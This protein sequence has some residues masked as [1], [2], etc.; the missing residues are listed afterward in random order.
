MVVLA[1]RAQVV[2]STTGTGTVSLGTAVAGYQTLSEAGVSDGDTVRYVIEDGFDWEIGS[3]VY[4]ASGTTLSRSV[5]ESS[6]AGAAISLSGAAVVFVSATS[7][8]IQQPPSEGPFV[9]GDKTKLDGIATGAEVNTVDSV[10]TQ[11]GAVVL[12]ADDISD[13]TTTNKFT[14]AG[15]ISKLAGIETSADVTDTAN[16][17][18]AG[19]LMDSEVTNLAQVK[20]FD[21]ADYAT[22]AQGTLADSAVQ[23]NDTVTLG[24]VTA[25]LVAI[26]TSP[27]TWD[28]STDAVQLQS[29]SLWN[30]STSQI[31]LSQNEYYNG[32]YKYLNS[33]AATA[34]SQAGGDH[35]FKAAS[36][37]VSDGAISY[38]SVLKL[39]NGGDISFYEDTGTTP[40]FFWDASAEELIVG[41]S[42]G[43]GGAG[44][45]ITS[46]SGDA[47][48]YV[49]A[50]GANGLTT[51]HRYLNKSSGGANTGGAVGHI[52]DTGLILTASNTSIDS[53][54]DVVI[55]SSGNLL[56]GTTSGSDK[57]TVNGTVSATNFNTTSDATLKTNVETLT[58][59]L[60]AVNALRG[61][62]FDWIES[63]GSEVG[64][65]AQEVEE[66]L[67][68]VVSTNDQG[69]KSVKY[70]NMVAVLVEALK[71][72]QLRIEALEAKLGE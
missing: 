1:N 59:S 6:N 56:V 8:D 28:A 9:D 39:S 16:V 26:N 64:F 5:D 13:T 58:G 15:D 68:E 2:T 60:D 35:F 41:S 36:S 52:G 29:G 11:T 49:L 37:G 47:V 33:G 66:V 46:S 23:P 40:K 7:A 62:S 27:K 70:G 57:V 21:S 53:A 55:D 50:R 72:Q 51:Q 12:D 4:T 31:N 42:S 38:R 54:Q 22:A 19:A 18:A 14:T 34:Y 48:G 67:P 20:A 65:I 24:T 25:D 43:A 10:N 69:I 3:G 32:G 71:E 17:T 63:G 61:V 45:T 30:Y 44:L